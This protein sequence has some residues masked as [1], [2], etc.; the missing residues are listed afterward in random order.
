MI[1]HWV[2][3]FHARLFSSYQPAR[4]GQA[5][6]E[7]VVVAGTLVL[8]CAMLALFLRI[9]AEYGAR[10]LDTIAADYP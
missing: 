6:V 2:N 1:S 5:M 10:V 4:Q 7:Y 8:V 3:V 9:F